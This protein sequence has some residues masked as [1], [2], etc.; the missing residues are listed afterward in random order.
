MHGKDDTRRLT[1]VHR[2]LL[3]ERIDAQIRLIALNR[4]FAGGMVLLTLIAAYSVTDAHPLVFIVFIPLLILQAMQTRLYRDLAYRVDSLKQIRDGIAVPDSSPGWFRA[5]SHAVADSYFL[6][7]IV[8]DIFWLFK[9]YIQPIPAADLQ[10][11]IA[12]MRIGPLDGIAFLV[13]TLFFWYAYLLLYLYG[14]KSLHSLGSAHDRIDAVYTSNGSPL[15]EREDFFVHVPD[16]SVD[17]IIRGVRLPHS[18][19]QPVI[20][21]PGFFQNGYVYDLIPGEVSLAEYLWEKGLDIWMVHSRGTGGSGGTGRDASLDDYALFDIPSVIETVHRRTGMTPV[22]VGHSQGGITAIMSL[23]G[24]VQGDNGSIRL[25]TE[26]A[27]RRQSLLKGL[28]TIGSFLDMTR[29]GDPLIPQLLVERGIDIRI[30]GIPLCI[31]SERALAILKKFR[32]ARVPFTTYFR[33][34]LFNEALM[35]IIIFPLYTLLMLVGRS[36]LWNMLYRMSNV[37]QRTGTYLFFRTIEGTFHGIVRQFHDAVKNGA[38]QSMDGSV[39]YSANYNTIRLPY[40][41]V[42]LEEDRIIDP[43]HMNEVMFAKL[44]SEKKRFTII[45]ESGHEDFFMNPV[46]FS[47]IY[48]A[49]QAVLQEDFAVSTPEREHI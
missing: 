41:V 5:A 45:R 3:H 18:G 9:F 24:A 11:F 43:V 12:R 23:M 20:L 47:Q 4:S 13:F 37:T 26:E 34:R 2:T 42:G 16:P 6:L 49:L 25:S 32:Y 8:F 10:E 30:L 44:G 35:K 29:G 46:F 27:E 36:R 17:F 39:D 7:F 31:S 14:R 19:K 1:M 38:M 33:H 15:P 48:R 40:S 22:Y 21:W 28:M